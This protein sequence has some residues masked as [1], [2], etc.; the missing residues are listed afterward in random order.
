MN[1]KL[2]NT[3]IR[4]YLEMLKSGKDISTINEI[5]EL[6]NSKIQNF[7]GSIDLALFQLQKDYLLILAKS[8]IAMLE[9][10]EEKRLAYLKRAEELK[11]QID[12]KTAQKGKDET[13]PY[14]SFLEWILVLK[15]YYGSDI[16]LGNDL[17][18]LVSATEQ[19]MK[20]Y[21]NQKQQ[22][23]TQKVKK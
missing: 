16:D 1:E 11:E 5:N 13:D 14:K 2:L 12:K 21:E 18:Y 6:L 3:T 22:I 9:F 23:E 17:L 19:M 8:L 20:S 4:E 7:T 15:K 10:D